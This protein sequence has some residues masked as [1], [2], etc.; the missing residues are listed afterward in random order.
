MYFDQID[1][2]DDN[3]P[4]VLQPKN[5]LIPLKNHQRTSIYSILSKEGNR[6]NGIIYDKK[7]FK[8]DLNF[9][10]IGDNV[11][12]GKTLITLGAISESK[13]PKTENPQ[14]NVQ[15][16]I[17][18]TIR[19]IPRVLAEIIAKY[20]YNPKNVY[21]EFL[22][23]K[24]E[25][26][27]IKVNLIV[28]PHNLFYQWRDDIQNQTNFKF[29]SIRT[30]KDSL[31]LKDFED[32]DILLCNSNKYNKLVQKY[33]DYR[34]ARV[35]FDEA[36][37]INMPNNYSVYANFIW[38]VTATF[39][40]LPKHKNHGF[41]RDL[42][43]GVQNKITFKNQEIKRKSSNNYYYNRQGNWRYDTAM[44]ETIIN[45]IV[46]KN[47]QKF[48][49]KSFKLPDPEI[50]KVECTTPID[51]QII[52]DAVDK[53]TLD[54]LNAD[55][56]ED[57]YARLNCNETSNLVKV[58]VKKL[59]LSND[60][61]KNRVLSYLDKINYI[62]N[63]PDLEHP[64]PVSYFKN[65]IKKVNKQIKQ[66]NDQLDLIK[67]R[68]VDKKKCLEC[69]QNTKNKIKLKCCSVYYCKDCYDGYCIFC[70]KDK[71]R[72]YTKVKETKD[73]KDEKLSKLENLINIIKKETEEKRNRFLIF[74]DFNDSFNKIIHLLEKENI[75]FS[76]LKGNSAVIG[77]RL[78]KF[79]N[80]ENSILMLNSKYYGAGLNLQQ[81]DNIIVYHQLHPSTLRQVVGR[82]DRI[83]RVTSLHIYH[84]CYEHEL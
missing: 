31:E 9:G 61:H 34:W 17:Y 81:A 30:V 84:L 54:M 19:T 65:M 66:N 77:S 73:E 72:N 38:F 79:N 10:I 44:Y 46:V 83:G 29:H 13:I 37:S 69:F 75:N 64:T 11:G 78:K 39:T 58:I 63:N 42:F 14:N 74:S 33:K 43:K 21:L 16:N 28:V 4:R 23:N 48:I 3:S 55:N 67:E 49:D 20:T 24:N 1:L 50:L 45:H 36:D 41:I 5:I 53:S 35:I 25:L 52:K 76:E 26:P 2:L 82:A 56:R 15:E 7:R 6:R 40:E 32:K 57:A 60:E 68:L 8:I 80:N 12:V 22:Q 70:L 27:L 62:Q 18:Q 47:D 59:Q 51:T 71:K